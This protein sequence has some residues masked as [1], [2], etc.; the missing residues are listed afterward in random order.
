MTGGAFRVETSDGR[1]RLLTYM[2]SNL[3]N[4]TNF[5]Y[6]F[7]KTFRMVFGIDVSKNVGMINVRFIPDISNPTVQTGSARIY[8]ISDT[9]MFIG[10]RKTPD[11]KGGYRYMMGHLDKLAV[12]NMYD[13]SLIN[14]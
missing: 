14:K 12:Y 3:W 2:G 7:G 10:S 4:D 11:D 13:L 1:L 9:T 5:A 6:T 8:Y